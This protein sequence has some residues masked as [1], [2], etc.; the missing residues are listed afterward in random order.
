MTTPFV[1]VIIPFFNAERFLPATVESVFAQTRTDWELLLVDDG[2]TDRS[3]AI[4]KDFRAAHPQKVFYLEH[5]AH[6]NRGVNATRNL[7]AR[8]ARG[9]IFAFLDSDDIWLPAKLEIHLAELEAH[10]EADF[11]FAPTVY[12]RSWDPEGNRGEPDYTPPLAPGNRVY[13]PPSLFASSYPLGTYGAPCPC[14]FLVRHAA[15]KRV[16]GFDESFHRGTYQLYEDVAFL[17]K[18]YL[19]VPIYVSTE[20]L[21]RNRCSPHSMTRQAASIQAEEAA[22]RFFFRWLHDYLQ[23]HGIHDPEIAAAV[24]RES[25][26]YALPLPVAQLV[27]RVHTKWQRMIARYLHR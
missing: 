8:H 20:C 14:S 1:S 13:Q 16:G 17:A 4:A 6:R 22:R 3:T 24:R 21:D 10:P 7:G 11:L 26:F 25:W 12:W 2:S 19:Q 9:S 23:Q 5:E 27:R 18:M 15:F